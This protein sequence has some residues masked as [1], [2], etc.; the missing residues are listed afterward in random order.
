M[1]LSSSSSLPF[2][3]LPT[4]LLPPSSSS[5][6]G[7]SVICRLSEVDTD[8]DQRSNSVLFA[9]DIRKKK[10]NKLTVEMYSSLG[11]LSSRRVSLSSSLALSLSR[12]P[13]VNPETVKT[14]AVQTK[15]QCRLLNAYASLHRRVFHFLTVLRPYGYVSA[16]QRWAHPRA[17]CHR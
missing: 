14:S 13:A 7:V 5:L 4:F 9:S 3:S 6:P 17:L 10:K 1:P 11:D 15:Q 8:N 16:C 12:S 2:P